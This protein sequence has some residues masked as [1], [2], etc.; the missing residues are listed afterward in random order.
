[1]GLL[2][3]WWP[4]TRLEQAGLR[5]VEAGQSTT[6]VATGKPCL[7]QFGWFWWRPKPFLSYQE[8]ATEPT[9]PWWFTNKFLLILR[10]IKVCCGILQENDCLMEPGKTFRYSIL[11]LK[12]LK[13]MKWWSPSS[14][15]RHQRNSWKCFQATSSLLRRKFK[16]SKVT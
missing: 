10:R 13:L 16:K 4:F 1:M 2:P 14:L 15:T 7:Q 3:R 11:F 6:F 8:T 5:I 12:C 9:R